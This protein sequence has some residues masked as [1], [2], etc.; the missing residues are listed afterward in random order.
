MLLKRHL[1]FFLLTLA[2]PFTG[3]A[4]RDNSFESKTDSLKKCLEEYTQSDS[5]RAKTLIE[6][7]FWYNTFD[8]SQSLDYLGEAEKIA[9]QINVPVVTARLHFTYG[10]SYLNK[11]NYKQALFHFLQALH[12][13]EQIKKPDNEARCLYNIG[14]IY[15]F[16]NK[17]NLAE[18]YFAQALDIKLK[19]DLLDEIGIAYTGVGYIA[20]LKKDYTKALYYY[21]KTLTNGLENNNLRIIQIAYSDIGGIYLLQNDIGMAKRY[22]SLALKMSYEAKNIEQACINCLALGDAY[23]KENNFKEAESYYV[24]ALSQAQKA[25]LRSKEKDAYKSL[26]ELYHKLKQDDKA[27]F[28]RLR[29]EALNDSALNQETYKQV[30][31]LQATYEIE[32]RNAQI[33][34]LNKEKELAGANASKDIL[35]RYI[36]IVACILTLV[37]VFILWRN[38]R[39]KQRLNKTL[40]NEN[41]QLE[42]ENITAK[43]EVL[44]SRVN[45][46]FL[47]NSLNTLT[48]IIEF[49]KQKA[50]EFIEHFSELFRQILESGEISFITLNEEMKITQ[51]YIYLQKVRFGSKVHFEFNLTNEQDYIVPSFAIQMMIENAIKHNIISSSKNLY[52]TVTQHPNHLTIENNLQPRLHNVHS[53]NTGQ[54]NI[55]GRY[56]HF[57]KT[58]PTFEQTE[59]V[60]K[61]TLPLIHKSTKL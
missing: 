42:A 35:Y 56:K 15:I 27:Y 32:K 11:A 25:G 10:N 50:I 4:Q 6:L 55:I 52:I 61:V 14:V 22:L 18:K 23:L 57:S 7:A 28:N 49:D 1:F 53:T 26:S 2:I 43:Y 60:Y 36:L 5:L 20:E 9:Q 12:I 31:D 41:S 54:Q 30:N 29:Y 38:I 17:P 47:F 46:H 40:I 24:Q 13:Y 58:V 39:L 34:L 37:F 3:E 44:K 51:N 59:T 21:N 45:P 33:V 19:Q 16:L 8:I 48:S